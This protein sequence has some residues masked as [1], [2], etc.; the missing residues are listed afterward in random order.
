MAKVNRHSL[1]LCSPKRASPRRFGD[2]LTN[3]PRIQRSRSAAKRCAL[4]APSHLAPAASTISA[5]CAIEVR[6]V[7][8]DATRTSTGASMAVRY[9]LEA[10]SSTHRWRQRKRYSELRN[11]HTK[12]ALLEPN[13]AVLRALPNFPPARAPQTPAKGSHSRGA[14]A[15]AESPGLLEERRAA[16]DAYMGALLRARCAN[17]LSTGGTALIDEFLASSA[18]DKR[19]LEDDGEPTP[20]PAPLSGQLPHQRLPL[21]ATQ[22]QNLEQ[23]QLLQQQE[24][25]SAVEVQPAAVAQTAEVPKAVPAS[26]KTQRCKQ[27]MKARTR[28]RMMIKHSPNSS[29]ESSPAPPALGRRNGG[30]RDNEEQRWLESQRHLRNRRRA[31]LPAPVLCKRRAAEGA[32]APTT[33][34]KEAP[35]AASPDPTDAD[36]AAPVSASVRLKF[37]QTVEKAG[38]VCVKQSFEHVA[39]AEGGVSESCEAERAAVPVPQRVVA[40]EAAVGEGSLAVG[41]A[42]NVGSLECADETC[43]VG[44]GGHSEAVAARVEGDVFMVMQNQLAQQPNSSDRLATCSL[45]K[46]SIPCTDE[47]I[48]NHGDSCAVVLGRTYNMAF[49][50]GAVCKMPAGEAKRLQLTTTCKGCGLDLPFDPDVMERHSEECCSLLTEEAPV[51]QHC[52]NNS[53]AVAKMRCG[54][55]SMVEIA[56]SPIRGGGEHSFSFVGNDESIEL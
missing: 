25:E 45:C 51:P 1:L 39:A 48:R 11:L 14:P 49:V 32:T 42:A 37:E 33:A 22:R 40:A 3:S 29:Q 35:V 50:E 20:S 9:L 21:P 5:V 38:N 28:R 26:R 12:L 41:A 56:L 30:D 17:L 44:N 46:E 18:T 43:A 7:R 4:R 27:L 8:V 15:A 6:V 52:V 24:T 53:A 10:R 36:A 31:Q 47:G 55:S 2:K 34:P 16:L 54:E 23:G 13:Q 19:A